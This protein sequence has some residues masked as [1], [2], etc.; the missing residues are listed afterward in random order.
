MAAVFAYVMYKNW[1]VVGYPHIARWQA[2]LQQR[3]QQRQFARLLTQDPP[4]GTRLPDVLRNNKEAH[5]R[6]GVSKAQIVVFGGPLSSCCTRQSEGVARSLASSVQQKVASQSVEVV[7]ILQAS[8]TAV[9]EYAA[10]QQLNFVVTADEDG[11][12]MRAYNA[13]WTPRVYGLKEGRLIWIQKKQQIN[14]QDMLQ[15]FSKGKSVSSRPAT[16]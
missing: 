15:A 3:T 7:L 4:L 2:W 14:M 11:S 6:K 1:Y 12:L 9:R 16:L 13:F 10:N 8:A 5:E